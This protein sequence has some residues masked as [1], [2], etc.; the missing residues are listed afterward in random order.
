M[1]AVTCDAAPIGIA[2]GG[3]GGPTT[4]TVSST[5][6]IDSA[7][8]RLTGRPASIGISRLSVLNPARTTVSVAR[9]IGTCVKVNL[10][11][12]SVAVVHE[13]PVATLFSVTVAPGTAAPL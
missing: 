10:P 8:F 13:N 1:P 2:G 11:C 6:A 3:G 9:P 7:I 5:A 4:L 12:A